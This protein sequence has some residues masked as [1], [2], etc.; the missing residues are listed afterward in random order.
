[1]ANQDTDR[2]AGMPDTT[3]EGS[4]RNPREYGTGV[5]VSAMSWDHFRS[6]TTQLMNAVVERENPIF[7]PFF[8]EYSYGFRPG[9][10]AHQAVLQAR[11]YVS[12]GRRVL[13]VLGI[14][15]R[16][17]MDRSCNQINTAWQPACESTHDCRCPHMDSPTRWLSGQK[18]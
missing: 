6:E 10:S 11:E 16:P 12:G 4:G 1:M 7:D 8:S 2:S 5:S 9:R 3:P 13:A 18:G 15:F 14:S 17:G